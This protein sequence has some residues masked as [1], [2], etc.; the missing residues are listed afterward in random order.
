MHVV[1]GFVAFDPTDQAFPEPPAPLAFVTSNALDFST[2][3][4]V[5]FLRHLCKQL[6]FHPLF[7]HFFPEVWISAMSSLH[8]TYFPWVVSLTLMFLPSP[9]P[10]WQ[11]PN[12]YFQPRFLSWAR[13][14]T[15]YLFNFSTDMSPRALKTSEKVNSSP[16]AYILFFLCLSAWYDYSLRSCLSHS[17]VNQ[18]PGLINHI[19]FLFFGTS[20]LLY[21][22]SH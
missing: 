1:N 15:C 6:L 14:H 22:Y 13:P 10:C 5:L 12:L 17:A 16:F 2:T 9:Y 21:S 4:L 7:K 11:F 19:N 18:L 8:S 3:F 20:S